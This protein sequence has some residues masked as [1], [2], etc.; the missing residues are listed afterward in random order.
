MDRGVLNWIRIGSSPWTSESTASS[1]PLGPD[2]SGGPET[3]HMVGVDESGRTSVLGGM[4]I[5]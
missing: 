5:W 2:S 1:F 3:A 4:W